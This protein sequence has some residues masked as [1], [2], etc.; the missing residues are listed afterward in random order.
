MN[1]LVNYLMESGISLSLLALLYLF[2]LRKETFFR[3][4]RLFLLISVLF[5]LLLPLLTIPVFTP[6]PVLLSE[7][8]VTPYRNLLETVVITSHRISGDVESFL[9]SSKL[10]VLVYLAGVLVMSLLSVIRIIQ[11]TR[12]IQKGDVHHENGYSLVLTHREGS[13]FSFLHY[14]F[15]PEDYKEIPG[16]GKMISHELE[17]I[18]QGHSL[19]VIILDFLLIIQW[20]NPFIYLLKRVVRENHEFLADRAVLKSGI[21][22]EEYKSLLLSQVAGVPVYA[23]N[24][25]NYSLLAKRFKMMSKIAS[26]KAA[27]IKTISGIILALALILVFACDQKKSA[28]NGS[29]TQTNTVVSGLKADSLKVEK[30]DEGVKIYGSR[31]DIARINALLSSGNYDILT[32]CDSSPRAQLILRKKPAASMPEVQETSHDGSGIE[33]SE[34]FFVVEE[35]PEFPGGETALREYIARSIQYP[36]MAIDKGIQGKVYISFVVA[37]DGSVRNAKVAR[38]VAP[39][40]D[41]EALR[42]VNSLPRWK[43]GKQRGKAVNVSYTIPISFALK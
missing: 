31:E 12:I 18:R 9:L 24:H 33:E 23:A 5:S 4:N 28:A 41:K 22:P 32:S 11:I 2:F 7:I 1:N 20:F 38:G 8:T 16:M 40:L 25:F 39:M 35:M 13:P 34:I 3:T 21:Q 30:L 43:P 10:I 17:H 27:G 15:V 36:A 42:V 26:P 37:S 14:L 29:V 6:Q 19:D